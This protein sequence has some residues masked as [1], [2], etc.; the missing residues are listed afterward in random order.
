MALAR[1]RRLPEGF[2]ALCRAFTAD[3][4]SIMNNRITRGLFGR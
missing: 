4:I 3:P 1:S 2:R